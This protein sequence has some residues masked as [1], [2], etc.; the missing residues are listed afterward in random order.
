MGL[1]LL[2]RLRVYGMNSVDVAFNGVNLLVQ[3]AG[4][5]RGKVITR[6]LVCIA[7]ASVALG[8]EF[9]GSAFALNMRVDIPQILDNGALLQDVFQTL[10]S[11]IAD[12]QV[13]AGAR[14]DM[15]L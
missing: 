1:R 11:Y 4:R 14:L 13:N 2:L 7:A 3:P 6:L 9:T 12:K 8:S 15:P 5:V 10:L